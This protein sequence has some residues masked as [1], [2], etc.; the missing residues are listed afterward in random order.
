M[1][2]Q[3][4]Q[5]KL[6]FAERVI[7]LRRRMGLNQVEFG[8]ELGVSDEYVSR[9][10]KGKQMPSPGLQI[11]VGT[12]EGKFQPE[13]AFDSNSVKPPVDRLVDAP[14]D[15]T[16]WK[17]RAIL[18]EDR[19]EQLQANIRAAL[20]ISTAPPAPLSSTAPLSEAQAIV[21][22]SGAAYDAAHRPKK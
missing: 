20:S 18:A 1:S 12:L 14:D 21:K 7:L 15:K 2:Q 8:K 22:A 17:R 19:L 3:L 6:E 11:L 16:D 5:K 9:I 13:K 10:E 4:N